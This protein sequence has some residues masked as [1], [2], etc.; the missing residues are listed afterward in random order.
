MK[1]VNL[2]FI[3]EFTSF[4]GPISVGFESGAVLCLHI[5]KSAFDEAR[6]TLEELGYSLGEGSHPTGARLE[7][8]LHEYFAGRRRK[9][10]VKPCFYGTPFQIEVWNLLCC[11]PY[12]E[13]WSYG[14]LAAKAGRPKAVRAIGTIMGKN[15]IPIIVPCHRIIASDG[16]LGGFGC[17]LDIK[18]KLLQL[19]S[20]E[21][22][23]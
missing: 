9:F 3:T 5:G 11:V 16:S 18:Q 22:L 21:I 4:I 14:K 19:E 2:S 6:T 20:R 13:C 10:T 7:Q 1:T 8:E 17:G 15:R 23:E 12:G